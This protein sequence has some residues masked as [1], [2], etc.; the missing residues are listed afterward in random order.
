MLEPE[1]HHKDWDKYLPMVTA[2]YRS[3][4]HETTRETPNMMMFG[5][6]VTLPKER[7]KQSLQTGLMVQLTRLLSQMMRKTSKQTGKK[8]RRAASTTTEEMPDISSTDINPNNLDGLFVPIM[9]YEKKYNFLVDTGAIP[10][11]TFREKC[12]KT[13]P[14]TAL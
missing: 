8:H 2:A 11:H 5:R 6:E 10:S 14:N 1:R 9:I 12:M 3:T 7:K 4:V 13:S